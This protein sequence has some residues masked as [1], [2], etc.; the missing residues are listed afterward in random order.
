MMFKWF[1]QRL[2]ITAT[3]D[4]I[5][6]IDNHIIKLER[7]LDAL[8]DRLSVTDRAIGRL[9]AKLDPTFAQSEFDPARK[10]ESDRIGDEV[11]RKL[12]G[13]HLASKRSEA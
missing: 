9:V 1:Q 12:I 13:E 3:Y 7:K 2:D 5:G 6:H 4:R 8:H 11:M 10:A